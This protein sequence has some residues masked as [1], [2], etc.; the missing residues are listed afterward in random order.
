MQSV[1]TSPW[2]YL[3]GLWVYSFY[4]YRDT[5]SLCS[6]S[7]EVCAATDYLFIYLFICG[8]G[9]TWHGSGLSSFELRVH[10]CGAWGCQRLR[11]AVCTAS[12]F[13]TVPSPSPHRFILPEAV[14]EGSVR[15]SDTLRKNVIVGEIKL[16]KRLCPSWVCFGIY[17]LFLWMNFCS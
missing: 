6:L 14:T 13:P 15:L 4:V 5:K 7:L 9:H 8:G 2:S 10:S 3:L 1:C 12:I 16:E 11:L 17:S